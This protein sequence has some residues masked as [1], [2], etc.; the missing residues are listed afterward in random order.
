[1]YSKILVLLLVF[2]S[3][4]INAQEI[5]TENTDLLLKKAIELYRN[6]DYQTSLKYTKRGL[7]LAPEYHDIRLFQVRNNFALENYDAVDTDLHYLASKAPNYPGVKQL[8]YRRI[9]SSDPKERVSVIKKFQNLYPNDL[10]FQTLLASTYL[11]LKQMA[12]ARQIA[13]E[14][15]QNPQLQSGDQ[16]L[17]SNV[18][19]RTL[20]NVV[21]VNYQYLSFSE[22]YGGREDWQNLSAE[23]QHNFDKTA[24]IARINYS[25]RVYDEGFLYELEAYPVVNDKLYGFLNFGFSGAK[26]F[27]DLRASASVYYN[28]AKSFEAEMGTRFIQNENSFFSGVLGL[29]AYWGKFYINAR[30]FLGPEKADHLVQNY[31][32][33]LRYYL[34]NADNYLLLSFGTGIS[35]DEQNIYSLSGPTL[36]AYFSNIGIRKTFNFHHVIQ[37]TAGFL[38]E[39]ISVNKSGNQFIGNLHYRYRF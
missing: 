15:F 11:D 10:H 6:Q 33:N 35:P 20:V 38:T 23:Y 3:C 22:D 39:E 21:A 32:L 24:V 19:K 13:Q 28:F 29:S 26:I 36:D 31:Q 12:E 30:S 34:K 2:L 27:P 37:I 7:N 16:Y 9:N 17:L 4:K 8:I 25:D 5:E 14:I 1:M 18:L